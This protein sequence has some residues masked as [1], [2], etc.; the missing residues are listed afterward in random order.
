MNLR[1]VI[2]WMAVAMVVLYVIQSP[3]NAAQVVRNT[4]GGLLVAA[5]S[6]VSF[7]GSLT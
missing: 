5:S 6:V 2:T 3:D 1:K 4:G 7:V